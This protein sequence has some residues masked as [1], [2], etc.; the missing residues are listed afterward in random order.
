[1]GAKKAEPQTRK[2]ELEDSN[3]RVNSDG[4]VK[5]TSPEGVQYLE[6]PAGDIWEIINCQ[7]HPEL[8]GEQLF[9]WDAAM[10]ETAKAGKSMPSDEEFDNLL[11]I[12][13]D[14]PN[15]LLAGYRRFTDGSFSYLGAYGYFWSSLQ[16]GAFAWYRHLYSSY[17]TVARYT[18]G[19]SYGFSVR[20]LKN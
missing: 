4:W 6:S 11:K 1:M 12:K 7:E 8:N 13:R 2:L 16:S 5:K 15:L 18:Y 14:M 10:R 3:F 17:A 20:C 9:T 19:K